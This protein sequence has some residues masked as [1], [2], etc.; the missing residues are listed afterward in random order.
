MAQFGGVPERFKEHG[1]RVRNFRQVVPGDWVEAKR[2]VEGT[3][4]TLKKGVSYQVVQLLVEANGNDRQFV[5]RLK[6]VGHK[7]DFNPKRFR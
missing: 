1:L 5:K 7:G 4:E 6:L 3:I 2:D